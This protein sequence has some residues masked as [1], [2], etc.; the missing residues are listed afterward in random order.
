MI[1]QALT[2]YYETL[3][4]KGEI[5]KPGWGLS[6]VSFGVN[7]ADDG[8]ILSLI[9]LKVEKQMGKKTVIAPQV[10]EVPMP[11]KRTVGVVSNFLCDHSGYILGVDNKG[12]PKRSLQCFEACALKH[13]AILSGIDTPASKAILAFFDTWNPATAAQQAPLVS[14][15]AELMEGGNL[16]FFHNFRAVLEDVAIKKGWQAYYD[17]QSSGEDT[18]TVMQCLVTGEDTVI[19]NVH[20]SIKGVRGAQPSGASLVSFNAPAFTSY[21]KEQN[22]NA[23]IGH[24]AAFAYTT[25]LNYL[26]ADRNHCKTIGDTTLVCWAE[27]GDTAYQDVAMM[28]MMGQSPQ[29]ELE[30]DLIRTI[31]LLADGMPAQWDD[32]ELSPQ[33]SF[34]ILGLAPNAARI[35]VRFFLRNTFGQFLANVQAHQERL[36]IVRPAYDRHE[37]IPLWHL[38]QET[39]NQN[40]RDKNPAPQ[41]TGDVLRAILENHRYPATLLN[42]VTLRIRAEHTITRGRAA[43]IKAYYLQNPHSQ[44]PKEVLTVSLNETSTN[45]PYTLGRLFAVL[46]NLQEKANP[47]INTTIKD[48]YFNSASATPNVIFPVLINL[49]QKH[50]RKL[51]TGYKVYYDKQIQSLLSILQQEYPQRLTLPEQGTF[52][53]GY[54]HQTQKRYEKKEEK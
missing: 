1:L 32:V 48:K 29:E 11:E 25:A 2:A 43:I 27:T 28:G 13:K 22:F 45:I 19:P 20:P 4:E 24:Y 54:Y 21:H 6:K 44:C 23:P 5:S 35:S 8:T 16:V 7:L 52:Q 51:D 47:G 30:S 34:Y 33:T 9:P 37:T 41:M 46:E 17:G 42:G 39:V 49:A 18:G 14:D 50:L 3:A 12:K 15:W 40:S 38:L 26:L 10:F 36:D 31:S 53:L